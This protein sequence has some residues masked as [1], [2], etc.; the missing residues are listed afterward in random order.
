MIDFFQRDFYHASNYLGLLCLFTLFALRLPLPLIPIAIVSGLLAIQIV[1][2]PEVVVSMEPIFL[3]DTAVFHGLVTA[4]LF[5]CAY[6][7][8]PYWLTHMAVVLTGLVNLPLLLL[9]DRY[10]IL[11]NPSMSGSLQALLLP[12]LIN[13][14]LKLKSVPAKIAWGAVLGS[15]AA[16]L[17]T[18]ATTPLAMLAVMSFAFLTYV[19]RRTA[20]P[21]AAILSVV[22]VASSYLFWGVLSHSTGRFEHWKASWKLWRELDVPWLGTGIGSFQVLSLTLPKTSNLFFLHSDWGQILFETGFLGLAAALFAYG[23]VL[24]RSRAH[25]LLFCGL[26]GFAVFA[27][28]NMPTRYFLPS[29]V[30]LLAVQ[31]LYRTSLN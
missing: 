9:G 14:A 22:L 24:V 4:L 15:F 31:R 5:V 2:G 30:M 7:F 8:V 21:L 1:I 6:F 28:T 17:L 25:P 27:I 3:L 20:L 16:I 23:C 26:V 19:P 12:F 11:S 13:F 29:L 10:G 18:G